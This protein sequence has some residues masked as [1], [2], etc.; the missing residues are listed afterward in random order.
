M[1]LRNHSTLWFTTDL[2]ELLHHK[3]SSWRE[4][5]LTQTP[6]DWLSFRELRDEYNQAVWK[7]TF[8]CSKQFLCVGPTHR[9][10]EK[11]LKTQRISP[12]PF[13]CPWPLTLTISSSVPKS[14]MV[15]LSNTFFIKSFCVTLPNQHAQHIQHAFSALYPVLNCN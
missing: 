2:V 3:N 14:C 13:R 8:A 10:F 5:R 11:R 15:N 7:V 9:D 12:P 1:W 6:A 4:A